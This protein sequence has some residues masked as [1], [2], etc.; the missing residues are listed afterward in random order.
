M[1]ITI[2]SLKLKHWWGYFIMSFLALKIVLQTKKQKGFV[3][4]KNRGLGYL[5]FTLSVWETEEDLKNF[6]RCGAHLAAMKESR[7]LATEIRVYT[8][9]SELIPVWKDAKRLLFERGRV[10]AFDSQKNKEQ[11]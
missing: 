11:S 5:H 4:M 3:S 6:A 1:V 9:Q 8:F 2:T 10:F 7:K